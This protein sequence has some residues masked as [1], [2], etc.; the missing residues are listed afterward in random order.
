MKKLLSLLLVVVLLSSLSTVTQAKERYHGRNARGWQGSVLQNNGMGVNFGPSGFET[1]Y[2]LPMGGLFK[3]F[4]DEIGYGIE[5]CWVR[6]DGVKMCGEYVMVASDL[7]NRKRGSLVETSL[8][9][10]IVVDYNGH[11]DISG[12]W[13]DLDIAVAW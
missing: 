8:G 9:T 3:Y 6:W 4:G 7:K 5:D 11:I 13:T 10:G 2:N 12:D 1:W